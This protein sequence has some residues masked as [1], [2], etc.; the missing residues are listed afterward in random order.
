M[1]QL[2]NNYQMLLRN[3]LKNETIVKE[4][5]TYFN[6]RTIIEI[7]LKGRFVAL[8]SVD[9]IIALRFNEVW[10]DNER[11]KIIRKVRIDSTDLPEY[12]R[13]IVNAI[14]YKFEI[15]LDKGNLD[16]SEIVK[17]ISDNKEKLYEL[18]K[19]KSKTGTTKLN[20]EHLKIEL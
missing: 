6:G 5:Y 16:I 1:N 13:V 10:T 20:Y 3:S 9:E 14:P 2:I 19:Q 7:P 11:E 17:I 12:L 8:I 15:N 18:C 4:I